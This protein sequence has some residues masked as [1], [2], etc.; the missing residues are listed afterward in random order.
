MFGLRKSI[1]FL[2]QF[3]VNPAFFFSVGGCGR[4]EEGGFKGKGII[5]FVGVKGE[6]GSKAYFC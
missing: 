3:Y 2:R 6:R 4:T 5:L 1:V